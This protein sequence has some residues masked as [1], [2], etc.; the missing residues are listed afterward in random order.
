[1]KAA[2]CLTPSFVLQIHYF[3]QVADTNSTDDLNYYFRH[4]KVRKDLRKVCIICLV[5]KNIVWNFHMSSVFANFYNLLYH[6]ASWGLLSVSWHI[7]NIFGW[8]A[9]FEANQWS[10]CV[11]EKTLKDIGTQ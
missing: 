11:Q 7:N 10:S 2:L 4:F 8:P 9:I 5:I 1:M 6:K 3:I